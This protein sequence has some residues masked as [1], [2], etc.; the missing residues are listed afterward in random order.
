MVVV[1]EKNEQVLCMHG[2]VL[3]DAKVVEVVQAPGGRVPTH[4]KIHYLGWKRSWDETVDHKRLYKRT[5]ENLVLKEQLMAQLL[6]DPLKKGSKAADTV[7][8]PGE[9][10]KRT[11]AARKKLA[12]SGLAKRPLAPGADTHPRATPL[13]RAREWSPPAQE[14]SQR[15]GG[16]GALRRRM[17]AWSPEGVWTALWWVRPHV[18]AVERV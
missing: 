2:A 3:Y 12:A 15:V 8:A 9:D 16:S 11:S 14:C 1:L 5:E 4:Y 7:T 6:S 10:E 18:C 17:A 13:S